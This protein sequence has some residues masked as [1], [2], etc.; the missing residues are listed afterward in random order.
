[1][2]WVEGDEGVPA[3]LAMSG[4]GPNVVAR[5]RRERCRDVGLA[6]RMGYGCCTLPIASFFY[7][8][9]VHWESEA[10]G[11]SNARRVYAY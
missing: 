8:V 2:G 3:K 6:H 7:I 4:P 9:H 5:P 11:E 10:R 1:M